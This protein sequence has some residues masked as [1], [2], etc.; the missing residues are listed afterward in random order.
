MSCCDIYFRSLAKFMWV[1]TIQSIMDF[2][3]YFLVANA[4]FNRIIHYI[5]AQFTL[6]NNF[7]YFNMKYHSF[8]HCQYFF[9][10]QNCSSFTN[11]NFI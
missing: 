2:A 9:S 11:L 6:F 5:L 7:V 1:F 3:E 4:S 8:N 10:L